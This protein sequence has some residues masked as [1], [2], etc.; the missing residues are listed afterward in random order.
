MKKKKIHKQL[1]LKIP[2]LL[3]KR[4]VVQPHLWCATQIL[5]GAYNSFANI[6]VAAQRD[7]LAVILL[8]QDE[9]KGHL[10]C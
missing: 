2:I 8:K 5:M 9:A 4:D 7:S 6:V 10:S 3:Q 1:F